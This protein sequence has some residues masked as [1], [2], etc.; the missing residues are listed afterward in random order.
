M[1][2]ALTFLIA[3]PNVQAMEQDKKENPE[4]P[5]LTLGAKIKQKV[6]NERVRYVARGNQPNID[7][8]PLAQEN[9][10]QPNIPAFDPIFEEEEK[11]GDKSQEMDNNQPKKES[12]K[13]KINRLN[14]NRKAEKYSNKSNIIIDQQP[15]QLN[16]QPN[17]VIDQQPIQ[18][19]IQPNISKSLTKEGDDVRETD[20]RFT[21]PKEEKKENN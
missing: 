10:N 14:N 2:F 12:V 17:I 4:V 1:L 20:S 3:L 11:E 15:I 6:R 19:P 16:V 9:L 13:N 21:T 18:Q 7:N 8:N 5:Q